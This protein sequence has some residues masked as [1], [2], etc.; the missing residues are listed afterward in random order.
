MAFSIAV[1]AATL[2]L[3]HL[4]LEQQ[5]GELEGRLADARRQA[6][7]AGDEERR[8]IEQDLHD[9]AQMRVI[10][11]RNRIARLATRTATDDAASQ[12]EVDTMLRDVDELLAEIR[13]MSA[14][15]RRVPPGH[16]EHA[17]RDLAGV[18][19]INARVDAGP[20]GDLS[21]DAE[22]AVFYCVSEALQNAVKHGGSR[23]SVV[24]ELSREGDELV[25]AVSDDGVGPARDHVPGRGLSG[26]AERLD[27]L[28]GVLEPI[29]SLPFGGT[30]VRGRLP[31]HA[32]VARPDGA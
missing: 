17:V 14:G 20:L 19:P 12:A 28:G 6:L 31:A 18:A 3:E 29:A 26:M 25:F 5:I 23:A 13:D 16:L 8:R 15:M 2:A 27:A 21:P 32:G 10:L 4:E 1:P 11:L 24:V 22:Q 9:G 7:V 30:T